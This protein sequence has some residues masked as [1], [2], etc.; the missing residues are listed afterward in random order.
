MDRPTQRTDRPT[1]AL[2]VA[3]WCLAAFG[4]ALA[5]D[6]TWPEA[7]AR[8]PLPSPTP[9]LNRDNVVCVLLESFRSNA[10]VKALIVLPG[11]SDDFYLVNRDQP[12]LNLRA[13]NFLEAVTALT[14]AT[15]V[16]ATF[17]APFLLLHVDADRLEPMSRIEDP[18]QA[19]RLKI[20]RHLPRAL[21]C[22]THWDQ[23]QP[24]LEQALARPVR[25][26]ARSRDAWH[27][28]RHNLAGWGLT[29]WEWL[30]AVS[31]SGKTRCTVQKQAVAFDLGPGR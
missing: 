20:G 7:L 25:P 28:D 21:Y 31:L 3:L 30:A 10:V 18:K 8:M 5:A 22:D 19:E 9:P 4:P 13:T 6:Q 14:N 1:V 29:D 24:A 2:T 16:R 12:K 17:R 27:F 26:Q 23:L 15:A 11:V